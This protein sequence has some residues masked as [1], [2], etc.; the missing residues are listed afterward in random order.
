MFI[1]IGDVQVRAWYGIAENLALDVILGAS[2]TKQCIHGI[3][4]AKQ[5]SLLLPFQATSEYYEEISEQFDK[6]LYHSIHR[7]YKLA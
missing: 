6:R 2:F 3:F 7:E 1:R 4:R 5:K